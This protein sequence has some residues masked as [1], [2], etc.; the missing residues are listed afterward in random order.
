MKFSI[1]VPFYNAEETIERTLAS[2]ISNREYIKEV[3]LVND[4]STDNTVKKV[5]NFKRFFKIQ[6]ID[7]KGKK[8]PGPARKTGILHATADWITFVDADDCLTASSL[9]YVSRQLQKYPDSVLLHSKTMTHETG[10]F[11]PEECLRY[12]DLSCGGNFY[13]RKYL[14]QHKLL[15]HNDLFMAEDEYFN[16]II[17]KYIE[18]Y[19]DAE[20]M[21]C[22]YDY[23]TY[24]VHRDW[25]ERLSFSYNNWA[26][27]VCKYRLLLWEYY[28]D[29]FL[30]DPDAKEGILE[31]VLNG[32]VFSYLLYQSLHTEQNID[33]FN[34]MELIESFYRMFQYIMNT[35]KVPLSTIIDH[36]YKNPSMVHE[37]YKAVFNSVGFRFAKTFSFGAFVQYIINKH[38][39]ME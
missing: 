17:L 5:D 15:P 18:L 34:E 1:I 2:F 39:E 38:N 24:Q 36:F 9:Y 25:E 23:P 4:R 22:R 21:I 37:T 11:V 14:I 29:F 12:S 6:V 33:K 20:K 32:V 31:E 3:I 26:D 19:G 28:S 35:Y 8:G 16:A 30:G 27:Y 7:N 13:N 10:Q